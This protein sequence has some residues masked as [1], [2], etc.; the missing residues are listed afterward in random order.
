MM[1]TT[2]RTSMDEPIDLHAVDDIDRLRIVLLRVARQIRTRSN[3]SITPS[4]L[5]VLGTIIRHGQLT[6]EA[7]RRARTRQAAVGEQD[8]RRPREDRVS[9]NGASTRTTAVARPSR[10][11]PPATST[12][13]RS[14]PPA[15]PGSPT[16]S[17]TSMTSTLPPSSTRCRH[18]NDSSAPQRERQGRSPRSPHV[19]VAAIPELP[20]VLRQPDHLV[21]RHVDA[22]DRTVV[23]RPRAHRQRHGARNGAGD[24]VPSDFAP[25]AGRRC[26]GRSLREATSD[27]GHPDG[28]RAVGPRARCHHSHGCG[29]TVDGLRAG[30]LFRHRHRSRQP[31]PPDVRDGDGRR[32]R[33]QQ[34]RHAQQRGRQRRPRDRSGGRRRR[35]RGVRCRRVFRVQRRQLPG[36][37]DRDVPHPAR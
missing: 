22:V 26:A 18:S 2:T 1:A 8:R 7:D 28:G 17:T 35:D 31:E 19:R 14:E 16:R 25:G 11:R 37:R 34:R 23:A 15:V 9:S 4:Q 12:P 13:T 5:V 3:N 36:G 10:P 33:R 20:A 27:H 24:A 29:R 6:V 32:R 30:R 21:Q